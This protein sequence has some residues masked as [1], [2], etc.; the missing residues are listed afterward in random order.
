MK[1]AICDDDKRIR[2][3]IGESVREVSES[4]EIETFCDAGGILAPESDA[5][6]VFLDIQMPGVDGMNAA[7]LLRAD[8]RNTVIVFVTA[9]EDQVFRAFDVG[10]LNFIVKPFGR[11]RLREVIKSA[12]RQAEKLNLIEKKLAVTEEK[13]QAPRAI[14]VRAGGTNTRVILSDIAYAEIFDRRI[15][16]HMKD[17]DNIEYYGR[18]SELEKIAGRD[19]F[20][21]HRAYLVNL[22]YVRSYDSRQVR[23]AD[24][25]IPVARGRYQDFVKAYLSY[26]TRREGL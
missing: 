1:I 25:D 20:R 10:A 2:E 8:G 23:A 16:L 9:F 21:V 22:E 7:R 12:I 3:L 19:F 11:E 4:V 6:I 18:I 14:T 5:D 13:K 26:C 24:A 17:R 15:I